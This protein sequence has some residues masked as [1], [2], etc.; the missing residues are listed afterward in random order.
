MTINKFI[1]NDSNKKKYNFLLFKI[2][3]LPLINKQYNF[4]AKIDAIK[5]LNKRLID[6]KDK[7]I[8]SSL[9]TEVQNLHWEDVSQVTESVDNNKYQF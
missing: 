1:N 4:Y 5:I 6:Q 7:K 9:L 2:G 3:L 8:F